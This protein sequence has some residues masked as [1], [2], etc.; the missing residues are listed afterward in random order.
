LYLRFAFKD[1]AS[2]A[3][4]AAVLNLI[5]RVRDVHTEA[6]AGRLSSFASP[7]A[8]A[9]LLTDATQE[10][11]YMAAMAELHFATS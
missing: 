7:R 6:T 8:V 1:G 10:M 4:S 5:T 9:Q 11:A 2:S 3:R